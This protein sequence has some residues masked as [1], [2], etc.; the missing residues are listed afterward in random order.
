MEV[1]KGLDR[2]ASA[3]VEA[4]APTTYH[5]LDVN[6]DEPRTSTT[7]GSLTFARTWSAPARPGSAA[8]PASGTSVPGTGATCCS[9]RRS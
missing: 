3:W 2:T 5:F 7:P 9:S 1:A 4:G 8:T 6:L